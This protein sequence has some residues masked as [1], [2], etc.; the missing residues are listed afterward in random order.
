MN[1]DAVGGTPG[2]ALRRALRRCKPT[3]FEIEPGELIGLVGPNGAGKSSLSK[4][5]RG[6]AVRRRRR[7]ARTSQL[8]RR[9]PRS[10]ALERGLPAASANRALA[11]CDVRDVVA[12][13]RLPHHAYG[14]SATEA[15]DD[16]IEWAM[17]RTEIEPFADRSA[18]RLSV[19][20]RSRVLLAR[21]LAVQAPVLFVDEPIATLDPYHQLQIMAVLRDYVAA[22][23]PHAARQGSGQSVDSTESRPLVIAVLHDLMLAARFCRRVLLLDRGAIVADGAPA[24]VLTAATIERHYRVEPLIGAHADEPLIVPWRRLP[25]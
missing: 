17:R 2:S 20:E 11:A 1:D 8:A 12:L 23:L 24:A 21:A 19:G 13:G 5:S 14:A 25:R 4:R 10:R 15:D 22:P 6:S 18:D 3:S 7:V 16:A 9:P